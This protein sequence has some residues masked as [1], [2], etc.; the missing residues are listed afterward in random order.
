MSNILLTGLAEQYETMIMGMEASG[1]Q[2]PVDS[3]RA[4]ILQVVRC[5]D[6]C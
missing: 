6:D 2:M 4:K 3:I 1:I 5:P